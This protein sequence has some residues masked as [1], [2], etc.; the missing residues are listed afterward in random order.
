MQR[1]HNWIWFFAA[2]VVLGAAAISVNWTYNARRQLTM[3]ELLRNEELWDK[4]GPPDYDLVIDKTYQS[5]AGDEPRTSRIEVQVRNK[6]V[7]SVKDQNGELAPRLWHEYD[8]PHWFDFVE[9][10]LTI[11][12]KPDVPRTFR[13]ADF[14]A[15]TGQLLRFTRSVSTTHERQELIF[16]LTPP[17]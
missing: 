4:N 3:E 17:P 5:T 10:F 9:R 7:I 6:K 1:N 8:M 12:T 16:R 2:L 14:D 11:D 15:K 13:I